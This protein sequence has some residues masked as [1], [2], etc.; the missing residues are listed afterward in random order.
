MIDNI[1]G[2]YEVKGGCVGYCHRLEL[3]HLISE[4]V[5]M[6]KQRRRLSLLEV[7]VPAAT[8]ESG[9]NRRAAQAG[10]G[11]GAAG[12]V[13]LVVGKGEDDNKGMPSGRGQ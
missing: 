3:K 5:F 8:S 6:E 12:L 2:Q 13:R 4:G 7:D 10:G 11:M 9:S 1:R